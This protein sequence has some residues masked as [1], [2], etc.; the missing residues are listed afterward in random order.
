VLAPIYEVARYRAVMVR[1]G[2][3]VASPNTA[4]VIPAIRSL[5]AGGGTG[6]I[7][8]LG[9]TGVTS[10][11]SLAYGELLVGCSMS[12]NTNGTQRTWAGKVMRAQLEFRLAG[13]FTSLNCPWEFW[14]LP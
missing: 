8:F 1:V 10:D 3:L 4:N 12:N 5:P 9:G 13:G 7:T 11:A 2:S 14:G 6:F